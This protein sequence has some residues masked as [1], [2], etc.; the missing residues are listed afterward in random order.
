MI[1]ILKKTVAG[2]SKTRKKISAVFQ[3]FAG[4]SYLTEVD[5]EFMEESL[6]GADIGWELTDL[7]L[8]ELE[9]PH[10]KKLSLEGRFRNTVNTYLEGISNA[11][12]LNKIII[13]VGINGTGK[14]TSA[15]KIAGLFSHQGESVSLVAADTYR[16][17]A[18]E[19]VKIWADR[20]RVQIIANEKSADPAA[21]AFDGVS[22]GLTQ[23]K[24]RVIVDTSGRLHTSPNLMKELQ[25]IYRVTTKL[26]SEVDVLITIDAN[27]GQNGL[28]QAQEF[29][30]YLPLSGVIL[31]KMDGTARGGIAVQIMK[32]L[33]LPVY[34][35][36]VGE[37]V[38]DLIPFDLN[39]YL[40]GLISNETMVEHD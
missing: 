39:H 32:T 21:V 4:K 8:N 16:A 30:R 22:S 12:P 2:L 27:T 29:N 28:Q 31:T 25:K 17:A 40:N 36:G 1:S 37:Q 38:D 9:N 35:L 26:T 13:L 19:Q 20:L 23:Q 15:A 33:K 18:V 5:L 7:I 3:G 34:Y 11:E 14:T 10:N 24:D 6:L